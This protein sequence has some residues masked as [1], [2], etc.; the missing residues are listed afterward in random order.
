MVAGRLAYAKPVSHM[1][2]LGRRRLVLTVPFWLS[3]PDLHFDPRQAREQARVLEQGPTGQD[4]LG[5]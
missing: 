3:F 4:L 2:A 1:L 5:R